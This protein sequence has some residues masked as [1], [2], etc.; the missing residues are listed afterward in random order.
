M[1]YRCLF[2]S[3]P[4][5]RFIRILM[6]PPSGHAHFQ[7]L[8]ALI[9]AAGAGVAAGGFHVAVAQVI[10][11]ADNVL[12]LLV[13]AAGK[14]VPQ[15]VGVH[16]FFV[17]PGPDT[18]AFHFP[19]DIAAV[20][21]PAAAGHEYAPGRAAGVPAVFLQ[22]L[23][24]GPGQENLADLALAVDA[25]GLL[26][27][28]LHGDKGQLADDLPVSLNPFDKEN[29]E[30]N[31]WLT[32]LLIDEEAMASQVRGEREVLWKTQPGKRMLNQLNYK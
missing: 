14:K 28:G 32:A 16:L 12:F 20:N 26:V 8:P 2:L 13:I 31:Y 3:P 24:Q 4:P 23:H 17:H 29:S 5:F 15:V 10:G 19:P 6:G 9:H 22:P 21:G 7:L 11:Q 1:S 30:P 25:D 27:Q 18:E